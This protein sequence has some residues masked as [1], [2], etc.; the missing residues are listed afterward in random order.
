MS[1][2]DDLGTVS[3]LFCFFALSFDLEKLCFFARA[4][5]F[6]FNRQSHLSHLWGM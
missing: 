6:A 5:L 1:F 3:L 2:M 4:A